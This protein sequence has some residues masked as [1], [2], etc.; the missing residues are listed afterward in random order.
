MNEVLL[1][2]DFNSW[3]TLVQSVP[4]YSGAWTALRYARLVEPTHR[5]Y[6]VFC[7]RADADVLLQ[8]ARTECPEAVRRIE[9]AL[10]NSDLVSA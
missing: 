4:K 5:A 1:L 6:V 3:N 9:S 10:Q 7:N 2:L 8:I